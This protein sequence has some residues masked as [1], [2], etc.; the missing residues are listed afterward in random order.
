MKHSVTKAC[1][2]ASKMCYKAAKAAYDLAKECKEPGVLDDSRAFAKSALRWA[3]Q[4]PS[5]DEKKNV[6]MMLDAWGAA[7]TATSSVNDYNAKR[8]E[9]LERTKCGNRDLA[10]PEA[11]GT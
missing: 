5:L 2:N 9:L 11:V 10:N 1:G 7:N 8:T 4:G 6:D 3:N